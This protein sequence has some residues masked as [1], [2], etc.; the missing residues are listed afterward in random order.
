LKILFQSADADAQE[1]M[2]LL[3][4]HL[5]WARFHLWPDGK[6]QAHDVAV[7]WKPPA[8][9]FQGRGFRAIFNMGAGVDALL[10]DPALPADT[11]VY[12]LE[13]AGM[14]AQMEEYAAWAALT[15][16]R[17]FN[18]YARQQKQA[19]W[20]QLEPRVRESF[21]VGIMG[22]GL[23]GQRVARYLSG[24]GFMVRGWN[25]SE[26]RIE[27]VQ[28]YAGEAA[29][30]EFLAGTRMLVC[31]LPLT[32]ATRGVL[33]RELLSQLPRGAALVSVGRGPHLVEEDLIALLDAG[34]L[35]GATLDVLSREPLPPDHPL[36]RHPLVT[37]TPHI[38]AQ[39]L[40]SESMRQIGDKIAAFARGEPVSGL[41]DRGK[42][43]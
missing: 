7:C 19:Q 24:M 5:P 11:P 8:D 12:R 42:G 20:K 21:T 22:L 26:R 31:L 23:L 14:G 40:L 2:D 36:W 35:A 18:V 15:Y 13:D 34:H 39:T 28:C 43:Y 4:A 41:I 33:N 9:F 16:L 29:L 3:A 6:D 17:N 38:S 10:L 1:S 27:G 25:R 32:P 30:G 37:I